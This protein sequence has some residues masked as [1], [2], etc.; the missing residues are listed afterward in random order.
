MFRYFLLLRYH[1]HNHVDLI[2]GTEFR[3]SWVY[4]RCDFRERQMIWRE[5]TEL[6]RNNELASMMIGNFNDISNE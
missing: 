5:L 2:D 3:I 6:G 4:A 1:R